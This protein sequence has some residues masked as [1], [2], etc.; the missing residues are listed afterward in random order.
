METVA[1]ASAMATV[2]SSVAKGFT[3][4]RMPSRSTLP[5]Q[6]CLSIHCSASQIHRHHLHHKAPTTIVPPLIATAR[7]NSPPP[8]EAVNS[9]A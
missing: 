2:S 4:L 5:S 7:P 9:P 6:S 8:F 1:I 3:E